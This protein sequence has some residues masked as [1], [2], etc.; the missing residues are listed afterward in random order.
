MQISVFKTSFM[1][2]RFDCI[3]KIQLT[4]LELLKICQRVNIVLKVL[5]CICDNVL[6]AAKITSLL[7]CTICDLYIPLLC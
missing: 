4:S 1:Y 7:N 6:I 3:M 2:G 5:L